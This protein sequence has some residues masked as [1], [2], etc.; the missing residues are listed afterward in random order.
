MAHHDTMPTEL[1]LDALEM[2]LW[3][4]ARAGQAVEGLVHQSD[5]GSQYTAIRYADRLAEAGAIASIGSVGDS[6][7][8]AMAESVIGLYKAECVRLDGPFRTLDELELATLS[9]VH[10][11]NEHRLHSAIGYVPPAEFE[12][13]Y[14]RQINPR[15]QPLPGELALH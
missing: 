9:W 6:Y 15:P 12:Q 14:Y 1:P 7:D 4:R 3:V 8:N 10:Y 13:D 2:A 5:A 11:F